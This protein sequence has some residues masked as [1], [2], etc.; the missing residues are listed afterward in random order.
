MENDKRR[1]QRNPVGFLIS[2]IKED[3]RPDSA[4]DEQA[5]W[6][7]A[8]ATEKLKQQ[9]DYSRSRADLPAGST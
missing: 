4:G 9:R 3:Y 6:K 8:D 5:L 7:A 2:A 1:V